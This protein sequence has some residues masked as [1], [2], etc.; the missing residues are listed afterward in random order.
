[1]LIIIKNQAGPN[2]NYLQSLKNMMALM[3][4][5]LSKSKWRFKM[6]ES[7]IFKFF[8]KV[9]YIWEKARSEQL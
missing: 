2:N 4:I 8:L 3:K 7:Q 5:A 9:S 1:M 6:L